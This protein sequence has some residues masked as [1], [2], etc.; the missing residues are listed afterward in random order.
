MSDNATPWTP[1]QLARL[2][3]AWFAGR[4]LRTCDR[5]SGDRCVALRGKP[6]AQFD[7]LKRI[8]WGWC[9]GSADNGV[10]WDVTNTCPRQDRTGLAF[11][12]NEVDALNT[13]DQKRKTLPPDKAAALT[14]E[15]V[16]HLLNRRDIERPTTRPSLGLL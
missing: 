7:P 4:A 14:P 8:V 12:P 10:L 5:V 16:Q 9:G 13:I 15:Y 6:E 1:A 2:N 3:E 11:T